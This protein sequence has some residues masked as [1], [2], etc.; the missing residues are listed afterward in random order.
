M[1]SVL[2]NLVK[3]AKANGAN[4]IQ[5]TLS[6]EI[7]QYTIE[8]NGKGIAKQNL[9]LIFGEYSSTGGGLGLRIV[10]R[11]MDLHG[12]HISVDSTEKGQPTYRY[13]TKSNR[14][15]EIKQQERGTT[16]SV[17]LS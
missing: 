15:R 9:P 6:D 3:N 11:I 12:G 7:P 13:D 2:L 10:R 17:Y 14:T 4:R 8:D 5:I 1:Y 16:F